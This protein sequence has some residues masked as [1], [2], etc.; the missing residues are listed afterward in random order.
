M[1]SSAITTKGR[2]LGEGVCAIMTLTID[3][4]PELEAQ[5]QE[6]AAK[7]GLDASAF[8]VRAL[9]EQLQQRSPL[10]VVPS[11]LS[12]EESTLLQKINRGLPEEVWQ[13]YHDLIARRRA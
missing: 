11:H 7:T 8:V 2:W 1:R 6:A 5:L 10:S 13:E 12:Q 3:L 9:E 4:E